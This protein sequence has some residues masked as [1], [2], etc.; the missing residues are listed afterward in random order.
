MTR[1][2]KCVC[3]CGTGKIEKL[4]R[5]KNESGRFKYVKSAVTLNLS[6]NGW[7]KSRNVGKKIPLK[8]IARAQQQLT[9]MECFF[10]YFLFACAC[11]YV[12]IFIHTYFIHVS[13]FSL[14]LLIFA[15]MLRLQSL[16]FNSKMN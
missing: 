14:T 9:L 10:V 12:S 5:E 15:G 3:V 7:Q 2:F 6:S 16:N 8:I 1:Y 4:N 13:L 11:V